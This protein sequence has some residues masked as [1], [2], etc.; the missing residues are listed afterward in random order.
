MDSSV[1]TSILVS[2]LYDPSTKLST[3]KTYYPALEET[4]KRRKKLEFPNRHFIMY[5]E[6]VS[7]DMIKKQKW[8][9]YLP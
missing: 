7:E 9:F 6:S 2:H 8:V 5:G 4:V 3:L 1:I